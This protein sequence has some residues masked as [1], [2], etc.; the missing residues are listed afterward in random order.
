MRAALIAALLLSTSAQAADGRF[1]TVTLGDKKTVITIGGQI[2][3]AT[4]IHFADSGV[5]IK[6]LLVG[7]GS[8]SAQ[9]VQPGNVVVIKPAAEHFSTNGFI[10]TNRGT[11]YLELV[12]GAAVPYEVTIR[13]RQAEATQAAAPAPM[14]PPKTPPSQLYWSGAAALVPERGWRD[15]DFTWLS[16]ARGQ[17]IPAVIAK[18]GGQTVSVNWHQG[19]RPGLIAIHSLGDLILVSGQQIACITGNP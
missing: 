8:W 16:F 13:S 4:R 3:K 9:V 6:D 5:R 14:P 19:D 10:E 15:A 2:G 11:V 18:D 7:D 12:E 1:R 17:S